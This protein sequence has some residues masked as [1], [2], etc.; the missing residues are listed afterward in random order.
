MGSAVNLFLDKINKGENI[1]LTDRRATRFFMSINEA[2]NLVIAA[3]QLN[4]SFKTLILDMGKPVNIGNLLKIMIQLKTFVNKDFE[5]KVKETGLN[6]GEKLVEE[7]SINKKEKKKKIDRIL[8]VNEPSYS[9]KETNDLI[10]NIKKMI[11]TKKHYRLIP[12][13]RKFLKKE[14]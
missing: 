13:L 11:D 1:N 3:S 8:E 6:K 10:S 4:K 5:I 9:L 2:C 7:L 12:E 14:L